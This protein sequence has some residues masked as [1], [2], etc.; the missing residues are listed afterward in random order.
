[1]FHSDTPSP[2]LLKEVRSV[3]IK[4]GTS[5]NALCIREGLYRQA[6]GAA[7]SGKRKG[8]KSRE[9]AARFLKLVREIEGRD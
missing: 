4:N 8:P 1:M 7:L 5:L 2:Q 3:L 6:V 9:L